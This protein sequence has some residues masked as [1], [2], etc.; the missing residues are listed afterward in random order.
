MK[1]R[2]KLIIAVD[3]YSS[4]GKSSLAKELAKNFGY[5]YIDTGAMYR[6]VTLFAI[7]NN[8]I[9]N[10]HID[11]LLLKDSLIKISID[12]RFSPEIGITQTYLNGKNVEEEI[13]NPEVAAKVSYIS[14]FAFVREK[15]VKLQQNMGN[16]KGLVMDGRDIGTVVFPNA[17][18][19]FFM[20]ADPKVRAE[21]RYKE[22][23]DNGIS[24]SFEEV[25]DNI[26]QRDL[27]D[28]TRKESPLRK[29]DD[30]IVLD[31]TFLSK[32]EQLKQAINIV[33]KY[34]DNENRN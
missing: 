17:N 24:I 12:F 18:I 32:E 25:L 15:L 2:S 4:C 23:V 16:D 21:R 33:N 26:N 13:R 19:K 8:I 5:S 29:A 34:F 6:A 27:L 9:N 1:H 3:G 10:S 31:N 7:N 20:T 14:S 30:A 28:E 22:L 11:E